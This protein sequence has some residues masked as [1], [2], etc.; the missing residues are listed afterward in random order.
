M[1]ENEEGNSKTYRGIREAKLKANGN[2]RNLNW[3]WDGDQLKGGGRGKGTCSK[4]IRKTQTKEAEQ[5]N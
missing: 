2:E 3:K 5:K 1:W 4:R